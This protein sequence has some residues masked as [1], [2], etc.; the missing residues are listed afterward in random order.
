MNLFDELNKLANDTKI[1]RNL[2][3]EKAYKEIQAQTIYQLRE[4]A[5]KCLYD[6]EV[7]VGEFFCDDYY[8]CDYNE[9]IKDLTPIGVNFLKAVEE[10]TPFLPITDELEAIDIKLQQYL[11]SEGLQTQHLSHCHMKISWAPKVEV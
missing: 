5:K 1:T 10:T 11:M 9:R 8:N 4:C 6:C 2:A 7:P 3:L